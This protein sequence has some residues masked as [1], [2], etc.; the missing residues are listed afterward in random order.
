MIKTL[1]LVRTVS[2][3]ELDS[4]AV[5]SF[6]FTINFS[7]SEYFTGLQKARKNSFFK[8]FKYVKLPRTS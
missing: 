6:Y 8:F 2:E 5:F 1:W 3:V 7:K 4:N